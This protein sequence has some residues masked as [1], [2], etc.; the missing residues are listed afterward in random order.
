MDLDSF[1]STMI[2]NEK[3]TPGKDMMKYL[4]VFLGGLQKNNDEVS[5]DI[6]KSKLIMKNEL[7]YYL[8]AKLCN[9]YLI[10]NEIE[11]IS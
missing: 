6:S 8:K 10:I 2:N 7:Y 9:V 3:H 5:E 11:F 4:L 1:F